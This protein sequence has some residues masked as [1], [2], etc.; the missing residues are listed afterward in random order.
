MKK[1]VLFAFAAAATACG[2]QNNPVA[3]TKAASPRTELRTLDGVH[4]ESLF[5]ALENAGVTGDTVD[6]RLIVGATNLSARSIRCS[7]ITNATQD[8]RCEFDKDGEVFEV[9][10]EQIARRA[11]EALQSVNA[12]ARSAI[13]AT[14]Y[15]ATDLICSKAV[16]PNGVAHCELILTGD[17]ERNPDGSKRIEGN[18]ARDLF[19]ALESTG[20]AADSLIDGIYVLGETQISAG[21]LHCTEATDRDFTK[22]CVFGKTG[23]EE[24]EI[25]SKSMKA[26]LVKLLQQINARVA[27]F[28][29]GASQYRVEEL[30]CRKI[31]LAEPAYE[32]DYFQAF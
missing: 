7:V 6:G 26:R 2:V 4:A 31:K 22:T 25:T 11:V 23:A 10:S 30:K 14:N 18:A 1:V 16:G 27:P 19:E 13:G 28:V 8:H 29:V 32:C 15:D 12:L 24:S 9:R 17:H 3:T 21:Y 5:A 20:W